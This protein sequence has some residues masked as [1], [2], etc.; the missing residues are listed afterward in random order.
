VRKAREQ[1]RGRFGD[2]SPTVVALQA[3]WIGSYLLHVLLRELP[4]SSGEGPF[5]DAFALHS[6]ALIWGGLWWQMVTYVFVHDKLSLLV[7]NCVVL[8]LLGLRL[9]RKLGA[10]NFAWFTIACGV[11]AAGGSLSV[12]LLP[13]GPSPSG[14]TTISGGLGAILGMAAAFAILGGRKTITITPFL[15]LRGRELAAVAGGLALAIAFVRNDGGQSALVLAGQLMGA[16]AGAT[17]AFA[18][19]RVAVLVARHQRAAKA[20][21]AGPEKE[22]REKVDY[23]LEK[24]HRVGLDGLSRKER[25]FLRSASKL[26]RRTIGKNLGN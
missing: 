23:L 12:G 22:T 21:Q 26:Y 19:P 18:R 1:I 11:A 3:I 25:T 15:T 2:F 7:I 6:P 8:W 14:S 10:A 24:V 9:E 13:Y 20:R 17:I 4:S 5:L 16:A